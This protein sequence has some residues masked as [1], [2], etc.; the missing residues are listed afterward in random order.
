[1]SDLSENIE[2]A[3]VAPP[4]RGTPVMV[5]LSPMQIKLKE[6]YIIDFNEPIDTLDVNGAK[7]YKVSDVIDKDKLLFALICSRDTTPRQSILP[8]LKALNTPHLLKLIEYGTIVAPNASAA[9]MALIYQ[10]PLGGRVIDDMSMP[11]RDNANLVQTL[12]LEL[13]ESLH[14]LRSYNITHRSIRLNNLFYLDETKKTI[15]LGDCAASFP[16]FH[17]PAVY[18]TISSLMADKPGRGNG[19]EKNDVYALATLGL[20]LYLG[21]ETGIELS[22]AEILNL[23]LKKGSYAVLS[24]GTK[25]SPAL[26]NILRNMLAD[27][28]TQRWNISNSIDILSNKSGK[29][30][31]SSDSSNTKK[32]F[33][34]GD[35]KY[36]NQTDVAYAIIQKPKEAYELYNGGRLADWIKNC[37][38]NEELA[39]TIDKTVK[40]TIDNTPNHE[41]SIAK[42]SIF[43]APHFPIKIGKICVFPDALSKA[44]YYAQ[45]HH[46]DLNDFVRLCS[47]DLLRLW[48]VNQEDVRT[49]TF[50]NDFRSYIQSQ[51]IG[52]G[53][54]R[55]MY[56]LD[57]DIPCMSK[58]VVNNYVCTP[59]KILKV[60]D[61][62]YNNSQ[63]KPFD[64]SL[65]AYLRCKIGKKI[66]GILIDLNS[67]I[68]ALEASAILRL[69]TTMQNKFGPQELPKLTQWLSVFSMPLI[70]SYHNIK[71]QKFLE[72]ELLKIN[73]SGKIYEMQEL[74][75]NEEA[76]QKDNTEY[77]IARK[78]AT[79]LL[80][81][82][83][84][85]TGSGNKW[86]EAAKDMA[87]K[88]AC[89]LSVIIMLISFVINLFGA[90]K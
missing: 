30:T 14:E 7:A 62:N 49:P 9:T 29:T 85:L 41:L 90:I 20:F 8:Y 31:F 36:Y 17:Q 28:P 45:V 70:K 27:V 34:L 61:H 75:E 77:S 83:R 19:S 65:I 52:Y 58:L 74:L 35:Q 69:Y 18:E 32:A 50:M 79:H 88:G 24:S 13:L 76:R 89:L 1:M 39:L 23:K 40:S 15:V 12:W 54:D 37:L 87:L 2:S 72:K 47:H 81:E 48:Y 59:T 33:V 60:L 86:E 82:K 66:D 26:T 71:Y 21:K 22:E 44:I 53:L 46:E 4:E 5:E 6:R 10:R 57:E 43:L 63:D 73:K 51:S 16:A 55:I 38:E 3:V 25:I 84:I 11:F 68:P 42:I 67:Q 78:T 80:H 56:E 64:S